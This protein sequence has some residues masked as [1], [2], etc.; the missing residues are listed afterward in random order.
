[1]FTKVWCYSNSRLPPCLPR[2]KIYTAMWPLLT[3]AA[4]QSL[5]AYDRIRDGSSEGCIKASTLRNIKAARIAT[6]PVD[7]KELIV[8]AI[9]GTS[10]VLDWTVN[11][12]HTPT[13]PQGLLDDRENLCHAGYMQ[14]AKSMI[15][16]LASSLRPMLVGKWSGTSTTLI[17]TGHS[18]GAAVSQLLYAHLLSETLQSELIDLRDYFDQIHCIT[19]GS[20]PLSMRPLKTAPWADSLFMSFVNE[21]D[22]VTRADMDMMRSLLKLYALPLPK[23]S[24]KDSA[25]AAQEGDAK[26][27]S[28]FGSRRKQVR[29]DDLDSPRAVPSWRI[30]RTKF[31]LSGSLILL[32]RKVGGQGR[33]DIEACLT[34]NEMLQ[35]VVFGDPSCHS[36]GLYVDRIKCLAKKAVMLQE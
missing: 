31:S 22:L 30:P 28:C 25:A 4:Q 3:T 8:V 26:P 35:K 36:I 2:T 33:N 18:A 12:T 21:G 14:V 11:L 7:E 23:L 10:A 24:A 1:M 16:P 19:F 15:A 29:Q 9:R 20:P 32:R 6:I 27:W 13:S 17:F 5:R 34:D